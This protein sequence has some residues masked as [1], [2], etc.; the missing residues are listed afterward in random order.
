MS[1]MF[2]LFGLAALTGQILLLREILVVFHGTELCIGIFFGAWLAGIGVGASTGAYMTKKS[3]DQPQTL[4]IHSYVALGFSLLAEIFLIRTSPRLLGIAP[5]ELAPLH[6][7]LL[8]V[9]IG[10]FITAFLTGF[11]FPVGCKA[12]PAADD[13]RVAQLYVFESLGSLIGGAAFTFALVRLLSPLQIASLIALFMALAA[14]FYGR[15]VKQADS[16]VST[17]PLATCALFVLSPWGQDFVEWTVRVRWQALHPGLELLEHQPTPYQEAEIARLGKQVSLF[18]NGKI[19]S[20]FPD[21]HSTDRLAALVIAQKPDARKV[22]LVGGAAGSMIRSLLR[23]P[24]SRVD[25]VEP[26]LS[27]FELAR[28]HMPPEESQAINDRRVHMIFTDGR[29]YVNQMGAA[30]YDIVI[31]S[32][33]DP[34]SAFWNRY[35]T[36]EFFRAAAAGL[37]PG[38]V[39]ATRVT[40]AENFWGSEVASYA[41]S[42]F[43]TLKRVFA[44]V[45]ATPGDET[46]FLASNAVNALSLDPEELASRYR[47]FKDQPFDP[48][49]FETLL[50]PERTAFVRKELEKSPVL[51]NTDFSPISASLALMLWGR[52]SGTGSL[53]LLNTIRR[54]GLAFFLIP[55]MFFFGA[56]L[57]FRAR[58]GPRDGKERRFQI[59]LAMFAVGSAAMGLQ[60]VLM[61]AYQSLFGHIFER[62]GIFIALFMAGLTVGGAVMRYALSRVG[63][64]TT[65]IVPMLFVMAV[66]C[67]AT[68][69]VFRLL[70]H[71]GPHTIE[72]VLFGLALVSGILT[73]G[74]FPLAASAHLRLTGDPGQTSGHIDAAD[75]YGAAIGGALS[76][77]LL[78]PL[79][80]IGNA[81]LVLTILVLLPAGLMLAEVIFPPIDPILDR[82]RA[83]KP[84]SFPFVRTSWTLCFLVAGAFTLHLAVG[85]SKITY[86]LLFDS[87]TL[88]EISGSNK[89]E[90]KET[91]FPYYVG[92]P[93]EKDRFTASLSTIPLAGDVRGYGGPLNLLVSVSDQ[94]VIKGVR[95]VESRETPSYIH[96][97][98]E[99]LRR[100]KERSLLEPLHEKIDALSSATITCRAVTRILE[101]T[102]KDIAGPVLGMSLPAVG[103]EP[104]AT[105]TTALRDLKL[106]SVMALF[107]LFIAAYHVRAERLRLVCLAA[108]L[109]ILGLYL[110]APFTELDAANLLTGHLPAPDTTWRVVLFAGILIVSA[111]W[112]QAFCGFL[113]PFGALQEFLGFKALR[114]RASAD[115]ERKG[116][117][118]KFALLAAILSVFLVTG[119][120]IWFTF[121]PLQHFFKGDM[122]AWVL[123]LCLVALITSLFYFR[124]WCRYLCPAGA[125]LAL[126]NKVRLFRRWAPTPHPA[127]CD[128]GVSF[129]GDIDCIRCNRCLF[130]ARGQIGSMR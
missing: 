98:D 81:C 104:A 87:D 7:I 57:I 123:G 51:I 105:W 85:P 16:L 60:I 94:G 107:A 102:G 25:V 76:G 91:P 62:V 44:D 78:V 79:L 54:G 95:L 4:F 122:D 80:G 27:A 97:L 1:W 119:D 84:S 37:A 3:P 69:T 2:F 53:E 125:F 32:A 100:F 113:C 111:L 124:F 30:D 65:V 129:P 103:P 5:A 90:L 11:L 109:A 83:A 43:H 56:R 45:V 33:P 71:Q 13:R 115:A 42:V 88:V 55:L 46:Q 38:G 68:P 12:V 117:Y 41:G 92:S 50:Q 40:A 75:H 15:R 14:L 114:R 74:V 39:F 73:G 118:L 99:W 121:S 108:S 26:D 35:Y 82:Y 77:T 22:L 112:G 18:G 126:F 29:F 89:F 63:K 36:M 64:V 86:T 24:V 61:Y 120:T 19:I 101:K 10:T 17:I 66:V 116:R 6:G 48:K 110:N 58:W 127:D 28:K 59:L 31:V 52:F 8:A 21:P 23:Y 70:E 34:V 72:V 47:R 130:K 106:W 93:T 9:P 96:G 128:L 20:S 49:G 67:I